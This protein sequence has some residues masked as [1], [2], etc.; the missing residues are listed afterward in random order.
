MS[1]STP[2][3]KIADYMKYLKTSHNYLSLKM[4]FKQ[5][6]ETDF[7][8][9]GRKLT[10]YDGFGHMIEE[11]VNDHDE[12]VSANLNQINPS[13]CNILKINPEDFEYDEDNDEMIP[14]N[15]EAFEK[16]VEMHPTVNKLK[17]DKHRDTKVANLKAK[18]LQTLKV[19]ERKKRDLSCDSI[20]SGCLGW[21]QE[22]GGSDRDAS[23]D[24]R[25][26]TRAR[27]D[28]SDEDLLHPKSD[29]QARKSRS[30]LKPP[31][32]ILS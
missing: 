22:T 6:K 11:E 15:T 19:N 31:K 28:D 24:S 29:K 23:T 8:A 7:P 14:K 16:L 30:F 13:D 17:R 10:E 18:V 26:K 3:G 9:L 21:N 32:I 4:Q 1:M 2:R 25:G 12:D 5:K 20:R 27:S